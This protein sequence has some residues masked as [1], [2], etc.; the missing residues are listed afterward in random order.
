MN[1]QV[2]RIF[3]ELDSHLSPSDKQW[4]VETTEENFT[5]LHYGLGLVIRNKFIYASEG[6]VGNELGLI[7]GNPDGVSSLLSKLY[8]WHLLKIEPTREM[9]DL[10]FERHLIIWSEAD[11]E[12]GMRLLEE[13]RPLNESGV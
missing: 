12:A 13:Q 3:S 9:L 6:S 7:F 4:I 8:W 10:A 11:K 5:R 1:P 2:H